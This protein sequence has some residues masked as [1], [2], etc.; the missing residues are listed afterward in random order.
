MDIFCKIINGEMPSKIVFE[1]NDLTVIMD[2]FPQRPGHTLIIPK[3][4]YENVLE[5]DEE[6]LSKVHAKAKEIISKMENSIPS[7]DG[8][9]VVINYGKPQMVKHFHMHIIPTFKDSKTLNHD[10]IYKILKGA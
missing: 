2:A 7:F 10:E 6:I 3:K 1:D 9:E 4:H 5:M 8:C